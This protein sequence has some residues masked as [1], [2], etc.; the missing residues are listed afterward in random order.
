MYL[1]ARGRE[2]GD[3]ALVSVAAV[4]HLSGATIRRA[5]LVLGGV[6]PVPY[7]ARLVEGYLQGKTP[8]E[9]DPVYAGSLAVPDAHPMADNGYK[10]S[11]AAN[12]VKQ[13]VLQL[14]SL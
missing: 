13:A 7:R 8:E 10:V 2:A 9:V 14:L 5:S 3:F 4:V 11:L 12:L 6:T 1:K